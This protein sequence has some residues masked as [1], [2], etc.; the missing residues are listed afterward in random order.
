[1]TQELKDKIFK[2]DWEADVKG[3]QQSKN[4]FQTT[5]TDELSDDE[6]RELSKSILDEC[7][8]ADSVKNDTDALKRM[9][10]FIESITGALPRPPEKV[11]ALIA[12]CAYKMGLVMGYERRSENSKQI[13]V[14]EIKMS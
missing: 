6:I 10:V 11:D 2:I 13:A 4:F 1:M 5:V 3:N 12:F 7:L 9:L 14:I 8:M